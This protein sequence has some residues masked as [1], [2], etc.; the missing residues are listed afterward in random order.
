MI[1]TD[2]SSK[3]TNTNSESKKYMIK[4]KTYTFLIMIY[5]FTTF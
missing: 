3:Q 5:H 2:N 4:G 1:T